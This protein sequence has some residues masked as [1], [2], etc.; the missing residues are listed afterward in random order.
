MLSAT[1]TWVLHVWAADRRMLTDVVNELTTW[2]A[3]DSRYATTDLDPSCDVMNL[4]RTNKRPASR[5]KCTIEQN[6]QMPA[7]ARKKIKP[8]HVA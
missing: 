6:D 5:P 2:C 7:S 1:T 8:T 3:V 4:G